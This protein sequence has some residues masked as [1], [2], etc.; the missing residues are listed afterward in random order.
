M[1]ATVMYHWS[2][3]VHDGDRHMRVHIVPN[4]VAQIL[5]DLLDLVHGHDDGEGVALRH[6]VTLKKRKSEMRKS[7]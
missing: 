3:V 1:T 7:H 2:S 6:L 4:P 5:A